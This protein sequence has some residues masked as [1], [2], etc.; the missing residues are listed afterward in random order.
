MM[1]R[2]IVVELIPESERIIDQEIPV[3]TPTPKPEMTPKHNQP[4]IQLDPVVKMLEK[5]A[6][7]KLPE[8][9]VVCQSKDGI[10][11]MQ[12]S[13]DMIDMMKFQV[14][15]HDAGCDGTNMASEEAKNVCT[16][17]FLK[18]GEDEEK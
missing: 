18:I 2:Q 16:G 5:I 10:T 12:G 6:G 1:R 3:S 13:A 15:M 11:L 17:N 14:A 8:G 9:A 7:M 4:K